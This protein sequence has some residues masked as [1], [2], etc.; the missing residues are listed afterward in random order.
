MI[1]L[2]RTRALTIISLGV[3]VQSSTMALMSAKGILPKVEGAIF[4]DTKNEPKAIELYLNFLK[5]ILPFSVYQVSR[6]NIY[7]DFIKNS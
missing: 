3:G 7:D 4:A 1:D 2:N 6:S 5:K